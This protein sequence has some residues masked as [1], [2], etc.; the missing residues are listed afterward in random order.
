MVIGHGKAGHLKS[1][2]QSMTIGQLQPLLDRVEHIPGDRNYWLVRTMGGLYYDDFIARGFV[3]IG[4]DNVPLTD[5]S[6]AP[7]W[8]KKAIKMLGKSVAAKYKEE[9]KPGQ[10]ASQL[11]QFVHNIRKGDIVIIPSPYSWLLQ[12]GEVESGLEVVDETPDPS[13]MNKCA[14]VKRRRVRWLKGVRRESLDPHLYKLLYSHHTITWA[15]GYA[16][17]IDKTLT[18]FYIKNDVAH[19]ILDVRKQKEIRARELFM[20]GLG[21]LDNVDEYCRFAGL[22][23]DTSSVNIKS[24]LNSP[25]KL[26]LSGKQK[27]VV[28]VIGLMIFGV[29]GG[30]INFEAGGLKL[31]FHAQGLMSKYNEFLNSDAKRQQDWEL[32]EKHMKDLQITTPVDYVKVISERNISEEEMKRIEATPAK[33]EDKK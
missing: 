11:I 15:T 7:N 27:F 22:H 24:N 14:F 9:K 18:N 25:G 19:I 13:N 20:F 33:P 32:F 3:A 17:Y 29:V 10:I 30:D 23:I 5:I 8:G 4:Y 31:E 2:T 21:L 6:A 26:E 1:I 16:D 28:L 12:L